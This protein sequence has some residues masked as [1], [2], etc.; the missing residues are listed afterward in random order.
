MSPASIR[1]YPSLENLVCV[2]GGYR[3]WQCSRLARTIPAPVPGVL[4]TPT[5]LTSTSL[6]GAVALVWSD[7]AYTS[8][9]GN[10]Q[11]YRVYSTGIRPRRDSLD[12]R[13]CWTLEG[14]TVAPEFLVGALTNGIPRCFS[15]D[16]GERGRVRERPVAACAE[17]RRGPTPATWRSSPSRPMPRGQRLP[18]LGRQQR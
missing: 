4:P 9:P 10:F 18:V 2:A 16:R 7:N 15:R 14:T 6:D 5:I 17:T 11:N 8:E 3:S 12:L 13:Q 1:G